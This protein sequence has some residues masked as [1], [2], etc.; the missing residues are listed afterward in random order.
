MSTTKS[1]R[2]NN[3]DRF[4]SFKRDINQGDGRHRQVQGALSLGIFGIHCSTRSINL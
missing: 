1:N 2:R 3:Q 4:L